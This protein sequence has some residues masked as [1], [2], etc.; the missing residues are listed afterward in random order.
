M[1]PL[2]TQTTETQALVALF[3]EMSMNQQ[4]SFA[5]ASKR[6]GFNVTSMLP[7]YHSARNIATRD[8]GVVIEGIKSFGFVRL[9]GE[10]MVKRGFRFLKGIQRRTVKG[11]RE[12]EIALTQN[13]DRNA[14]LQASS[15]LNRFRLM[16]DIAGKPASN[17]KTVEEPE[18]IARHGR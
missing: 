15:N 11:A 7:A 6:V 16:G 17:R 14:Q 2:F 10:G 9:N 1:R 13:L 12:Q 18:L 5:E 4:M 8:H 3:Q